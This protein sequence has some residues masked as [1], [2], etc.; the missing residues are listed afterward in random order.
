MEGILLGFD[1]N[2]GVVEGVRLG[3]DIGD[4]DGD[5]FGM[6]DLDGDPLGSE[7]GLNDGLNEGILLGFDDGDSD[8]D[9]E[10]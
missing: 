5:S 6:I 7:L 3:L 8:G 2:D 4:S 9:P 1:E 10:G